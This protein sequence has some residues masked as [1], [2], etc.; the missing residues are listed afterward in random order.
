MSM[1]MGEY[2]AQSDKLTLVD[3]GLG[4]ESEVFDAYPISATNI[5]SPK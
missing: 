2:I 5:S 1:V 3:Y 4:S